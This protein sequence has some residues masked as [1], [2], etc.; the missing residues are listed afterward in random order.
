MKTGEFDRRDLETDRPA[1]LAWRR[2]SLGE[3]LSVSIIELRKGASIPPTR[4]RHDVTIIVLSGAWHFYLLG[5]EVTVEARDM[6]S[7]PAGAECS[8]EALHDTLAIEIVRPAAAATAA[9]GSDVTDDCL[10]A[11]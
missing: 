7:I 9:D 8:W 3:R 2:R 11:V 1:A 6:F 4:R 10:W 5:R